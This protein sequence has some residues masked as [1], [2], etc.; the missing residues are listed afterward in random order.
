MSEEELQIVKLEGTKWQQ[1]VQS[2]KLSNQEKSAIHLCKLI[3]PLINWQAISKFAWKCIFAVSARISVKFGAVFGWFFGSIHLLPRLHLEGLLSAFFD[4]FT[5]ER[6]RRRKRKTKKLAEKGVPKGGTKI[7]QVLC[8]ETV[9]PFTFDLEHFGN[10]RWDRI[11][12]ESWRSKE[13]QIQAWSKIWLDVWHPWIEIRKTSSTS[14]KIHKKRGF[15]V[16]RRQHKRKYRI[17]FAP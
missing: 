7:L 13:L 2:F 4:I 10:P 3:Q 9:I 16:I 5:S 6:R 1:N 17:L 11:N 12:K 14:K 15:Q 8:E